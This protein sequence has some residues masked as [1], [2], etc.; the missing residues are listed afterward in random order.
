MQRDWSIYLNR[1]IIVYADKW[2]EFPPVIFIQKFRMSVQAV[3]DTHQ[4]QID[5]KFQTYQ[6]IHYS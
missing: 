5:L 6:H 3:E 1:S 2:G 4:I